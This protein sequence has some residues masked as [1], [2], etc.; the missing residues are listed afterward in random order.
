MTYAYAQH[1]ITSVAVGPTGHTHDRSLPITDETPT[2]VE[3]AA[4][5]PYL[6]REGWYANPELVPLTERQLKERERIER[7]GNLAVKEVTA[8]LAAS[9]ASAIAGRTVTVEDDDDDDPDVQKVNVVL[10]APRRGARTTTAVVDA[11]R[12]GPGRP[13]KNP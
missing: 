1:T 3:C 13:R 6:I 9:A 4:C 8:A 2:V 5:A 7:E 11:P 12:R 10:E